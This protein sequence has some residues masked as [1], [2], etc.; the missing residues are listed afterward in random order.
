MRREN[1]LKNNFKEQMQSLTLTIF[2]IIFVVMVVIPFTI[3]VATICI[4]GMAIWWALGGRI[5]TAHGY[6]RWFTKY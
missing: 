5:L 3:T 6:I 1:I 4:G 2:A